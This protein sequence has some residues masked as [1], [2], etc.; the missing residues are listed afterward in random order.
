MATI[1]QLKSGS[2]RIRKTYKGNNYAVTLNY[3]PSKVEAD[4]ILYDMINKNQKSMGKL[5]FK[6]A[7][8]DYIDLKTPVLSPSTIRGYTADL[9]NFDDKTLN[10]LV[11]KFDS[12]RV[13]LIVNEMYKSGLAP[14]TI[15]NRINFLITVIK[16]LRP[17]LILKVEYPKKNTEE[18]YI[19]TDEEYTKLLQA[20]KGTEYEVALYLA[21]MGLRRSEICAL[22][23]EDV[24]EDGVMI[25]KAKVPIAGGYAITERNKTEK[26]CRFVPLPPKIIELIKEQGY[27]YKGSPNSIN[28]F[29][30]KA[31][32]KLNIND[33][34][35]HKLRHFFATK[36]H[37][38]MIPD[39]TILATGGWKTDHV[40]KNVYR[41][42]AQDKIKQD[43]KKLQDHIFN[44]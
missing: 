16:D 38:L 26:S 23:L 36:A 33:F 6:K 15:K 14:K 1:T 8:E 25:N 42:A 13:Q 3:K 18:P 21:G 44:L 32:K 34:T 28:N 11:S 31:V 9:R 41:H 19:P 37:S 12:K 39:A 7:A 10:T 30:H 4:R 43:I 2:Y 24:T 29:I 17:E 40:M 22:T 27:I 35:L 20:A 5:T